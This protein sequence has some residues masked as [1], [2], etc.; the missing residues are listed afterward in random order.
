MFSSSLILNH[1]KP[2]SLEPYKPFAALFSMRAYTFLGLLGAMA[3]PIRPKSPS[4]KPSSLVRLVQVSPPSK[5]TYMPLPS[6]P[7]LKIQ[8]QRRYSHIAQMSL[9]G[10]TGS[11]TKSAAPV[12]SLL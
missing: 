8:G 6:P 3:M 7:L 11:M 2:P 12:R 9:L 1:L 10:L 5:V 4:G